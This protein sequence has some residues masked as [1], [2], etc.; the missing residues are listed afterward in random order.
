MMNHKDTRDIQTTYF[1][2]RG[3]VLKINRAKWPSKAVLCAV[4][5]LQKNTYS[6]RICEVFDTQDGT[7]HA[8]LA[9]R[10]VKGESVLAIA[11][12]RDP[13]ITL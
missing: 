2:H 12:K 6:A 4:Q 8:V 7:L 3:L 1:D 11:Y 10:L 5:H 13:E 9:K